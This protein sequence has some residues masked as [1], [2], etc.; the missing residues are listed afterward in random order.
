MRS[1]AVVTAGQLAMV[2]VAAT[3]LLGFTFGLRGVLDAPH[4]DS[5]W[6]IGAVLG[7]SARVLAFRIYRRARIAIDSPIYVSIAFQLNVL[8]AAW[9]VVAVL[10]MDGIV[11]TARRILTGSVHGSFYRAILE[12]AY[13]AAAPSLFML[14]LGFA[15]QL[16]RMPRPLDITG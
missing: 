4:F 12:R 14:M 7:A 9:L 5:R 6:W 11:R 2:I 16:D 15:F 13:I 10:G 3:A 1:R 8:S